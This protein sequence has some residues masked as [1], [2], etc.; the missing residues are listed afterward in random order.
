MI[1]NP[2]YIYTQEHTAY[3]LQKLKGEPYTFC[4]TIVGQGNSGN[5]WVLKKYNISKDVTVSI[6]KAY[7]NIQNI[8]TTLKNSVDKTIFYIDLFFGDAGRNIYADRL[9]IISSN[10]SSSSPASSSSSPGSVASSAPNTTVPLP[11]EYANIPLPNELKELESLQLLDKY[12]SLILPPD[13]LDPEY[14]PGK[15]SYLTDRIF[16]LKRYFNEINKIN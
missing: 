1:E 9:A 4:N 11:V 2:K 12:S 16:T 13:Q 6:D 14:K 3:I 15:M 8:K 10:Q 5:H 7:D